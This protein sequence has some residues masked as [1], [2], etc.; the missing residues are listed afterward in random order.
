MTPFT[1][2]LLIGAVGGLVIGFCV[3]Y[4]LIKE[5]FRRE[6]RMGYVDLSQARRDAPYWPEIRWVATSEGYDAVTQEE[7]R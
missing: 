4:V 1:W 3:A 7:K 6:R 5:G 2:G